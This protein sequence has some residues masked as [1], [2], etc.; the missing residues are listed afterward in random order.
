MSV[1]NVALGGK[2]YP[3]Y[4]GGSALLDGQTMNSLNQKS[5][6]KLRCY[7]CDKKV[8]RFTDVKWRQTVDYMFVRNHN[9]NPKELIKVKQ[10]FVERYR[11]LKVHQDMQHMLANANGNL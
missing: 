2:C 4:M 1:S 9:T 11:D 3:L 5:C 7:N 10:R 8:H 6:D